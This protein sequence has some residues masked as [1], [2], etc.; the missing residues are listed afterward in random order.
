MPRHPKSP[1]ARHTE[2][3][4]L[5][6]KLRSVGLPDEVTRPIVEAMTHFETTGQ[7]FTCTV[8]VPGTP[9]VLKCLLSNQAHI[10]SYIHIT[11]G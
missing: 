6:E 1:E 4:L 8:R 10:T 5:T 9:I 2:V 3:H 7:G 11:R